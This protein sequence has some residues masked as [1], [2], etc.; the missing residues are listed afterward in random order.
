[1]DHADEEEKQYARI[2][3]LDIRPKDMPEKLTQIRER[4]GKYEGYQKRMKETGE[5]QIQETDPEC[6]TIYTKEGLQPA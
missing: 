4:I 1:M 5:D 2:L 6:R 3:E